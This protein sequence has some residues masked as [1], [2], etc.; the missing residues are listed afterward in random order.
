MF[1][2]FLAVAI[3]REVFG[4]PVTF[5][6]TSIT[7]DPPPRAGTPTLPIPNLRPSWDLDGLYLWVGPTGTA[8]FVDT[9][10]DSTFGADAT[11]VRVREHEPL[12]VIGASLGAS[13]WTVRDGGRLWLDGLVGTSVGRMVGLSLGPIV[14]L[15]SDAHP[16]VGGSIGIWGFVGVTPYARVGA[17]DELGTFAEVGVHIALPVLRH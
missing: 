2:C 10:W 12:G 14:E 4:D 6:P 5:E 11:V 13:R 16:R 9:K 15:A 17:V 7:P 3:P 1:A 8:S